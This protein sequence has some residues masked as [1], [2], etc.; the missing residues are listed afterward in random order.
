M[1]WLH[2]Y[3]LHIQ[4]PREK[5]YRMKKKI[6]VLE[7]DSFEIETLKGRTPGILE[8]MC[9]TKLSVIVNKLCRV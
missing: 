6:V 5:L 7:G 4:N 2:H 9:N 3:R 8:Q 1:K